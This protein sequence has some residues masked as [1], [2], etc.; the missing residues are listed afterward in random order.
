[1]SKELEALKYLVAIAE[2]VHDSVCEITGLE[3]ST[4]GRFIH[5]EY[6]RELRAGLRAT[7]QLIYEVEHPTETVPTPPAVPAPESAPPSLGLSADQA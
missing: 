5:N 6:L 3:T 1:M 2:S 4:E 7:R